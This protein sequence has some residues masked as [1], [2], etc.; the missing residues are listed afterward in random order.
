MLDSVIR[1]LIVVR[2]EHCV[3][4]FRFVGAAAA[5]VVSVRFW[6]LFIFEAGSVSGLIC[7]LTLDCCSLSGRFGRQLVAGFVLTV[8]VIDSSSKSSKSAM[9][10]FCHNWPFGRKLAVV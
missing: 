10:G 1:L 2:L 8:V 5:A 6:E 7:L 9:L 3:E 4:V